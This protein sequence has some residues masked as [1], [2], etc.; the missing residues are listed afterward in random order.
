ML[1]AGPAGGR[2]VLLAILDPLDRHRELR[3]REHDRHLFALD[4]D[5]LPEAAPRVPG[6]RPDPVLG[7]PEQPRAERPVL[8]RCLRRH[9]HGDLT[10]AG[11]A[12]DHQPSGLEGH[13]CVGL[14]V[15]RAFDEVRR[16]RERGLE[17]LERRAVVVDHVRPVRLVDQLV[18]IDRGLVVHDRRRGS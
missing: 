12:L 1:V 10:G 9:P 14:L 17:P 13:R 6:D 5:L 15:D 11:I 7:D 4:E 8:V 3:G 18:G 16:V 2:Q